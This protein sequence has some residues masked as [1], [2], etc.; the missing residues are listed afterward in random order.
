M[1]LY[2]VVRLYVTLCVI[3]CNCGWWCGVGFCVKLCDSKFHG[4]VNKNCL[5]FKLFNTTLRHV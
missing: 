4:T 2:D 1:I 5:K 3:L